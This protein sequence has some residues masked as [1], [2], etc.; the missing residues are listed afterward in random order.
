MCVKIDFTG[1]SVQMSSR[2]F[3]KVFIMLLLPITSLRS[4]E[5]KRQVNVI[6][7]GFL[8]NTFFFFLLHR[9]E[10]SLASYMQGCQ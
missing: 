6:Y 2:S 3:H 8:T 10:N 4:T 9:G 1:Y 7:P 5:G